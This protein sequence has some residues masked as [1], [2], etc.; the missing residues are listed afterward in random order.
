MRNSL[1][2]DTRSSY[3]QEMCQE[4]KGKTVRRDLSGAFTIVSIGE[5]LA[6]QPADAGEILPQPREREF[7]SAALESIASLMK[8]PLSDRIECSEEDFLEEA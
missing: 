3:L 2:K 7:R 8:D 5:P 1:A 6:K 4:T